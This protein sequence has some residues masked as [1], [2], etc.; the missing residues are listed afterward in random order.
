M[1]F[2][3]IHVPHIIRGVFGFLLNIKLPKSHEIIEK[4]G[5]LGNEQMTFEQFSEKAT[6]LMRET[7]METLQSVEKY[8]QIYFS[9][10]IICVILDF[11][12]FI[13]QLI[14]FGRIGDVKLIC[15]NIFR[16][17]QI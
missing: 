9:L 5:L 10:T 8:L 14:R 7:F 1:A 15:I 16:N 2:I 13:I 12:E 4:I 6:Q 3:F 11:I 17:T